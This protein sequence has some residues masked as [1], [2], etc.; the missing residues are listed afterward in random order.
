MGY[1]DD[2]RGLP[3]EAPALPA[4]PPKLLP[5]KRA[6]LPGGVLATVMQH[7]LDHLTVGI[8]SPGTTVTHHFSGAAFDLLAD[9]LFRAHEDRAR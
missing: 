9:L 4:E 2:F 8:T 5:L 6:E 1:P 3:G 7:G